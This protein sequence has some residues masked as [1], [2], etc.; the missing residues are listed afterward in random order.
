MLVGL[1]CWLGQKGVSGIP[2]T[3]LAKEEVPELVRSWVSLYFVSWC[4]MPG[5]LDFVRLAIEFED[6]FCITVHYVV[7]LKPELEKL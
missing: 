6:D 3:D 4:Q 7:I 2:S 1:T 5:V